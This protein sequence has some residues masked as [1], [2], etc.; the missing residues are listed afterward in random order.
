ML[1]IDHD[2]KVAV[3]RFERGV[4]N[5]L[6]PEF[7]QR[8][9]EALDEVR[10]DDE[11]RG[12][13]LT[14]SNDKFFSIGF[15]LPEIFKLSRDGFG[16]FYRTFN[17]VC[18]KLYTLPKPTVAALTGHATAGGCILAICCDYRFIAEGRKLMGLNEIKLGVPMPFLTDRILRSLTG[19]RNARDIC[20]TGNFYEPDECGAIG[21]ADLVL[22][23]DEVLPR[24]I[25]K[26]RTIGL[27]VPRAFAGIKRDRTEVIEREYLEREAQDVEEFKDYWF[28]DES[29]KLQREAMA[30][31]EKR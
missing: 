28:T 2:D 8:I 5:A 19:F 20:D 31:F 17:R 3:I 10:S 16:E 18:L 22:S 25:E 14:G 11:V 1:T 6:S 7:I 13:V 30:R 23:E 4:I 27:E 29:R 26:A 21:L 24:A 9:G 15:D 12:V